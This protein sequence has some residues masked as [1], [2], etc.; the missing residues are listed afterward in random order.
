[1]DH[2]AYLATLPADQRTR[3]Q[4]KCDAAGLW[5]LFVHVAVIVLFGLLIALKVPGWPVLMVPQGIA[6]AFLFN[7]QHEC[8]H[9]TPFR[10]DWLNEWVGHCVGWVIVQPFLWFRYFHYAH[11]RTPMTHSVIRS[12]L[13]L[14]NRVPFANTCFLCLPSATH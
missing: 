14:S 1:M 12:W 9:K 11:H 3:L 4:H 13:Y 7:L 2:R 8:T 6:L 10:T 5:R